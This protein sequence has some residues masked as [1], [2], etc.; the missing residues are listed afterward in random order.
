VALHGGTVKALTFDVFGTVVDYRGTIIREGAELNR[1]RGWD[2][3]WAALAD[4]WRR[5]YRPS[6]DRVNRGQLPWSNLDEL[7]RLALEEVLAGFAIKSLTEEDKSQLNR[8][9]H[10]LEPWPDAITGLVRLRKQFIVATLSNG[11]VALLVNMAKR[12]DIPWDCVLSSELAKIYKPDPRVYEMS[13]ALLGLRPQEVMMV[14]AHQFDLRAAKA[15]G[16][17]AAFVPRPLEFGPSNPPDPTPDP[18]FDV[19]ATD[20]VD[21]ARQLGA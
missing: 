1:T 14:A 19:V 5:R 6:L 10:R 20:F 2:I 18:E 8:V 3:D 21:L 16:L 17:R 9:W 12:S 11:N 13:V 7:H 4:A 15:C